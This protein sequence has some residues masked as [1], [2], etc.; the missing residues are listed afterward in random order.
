MP[1][2]TFNIT[3]IDLY[4]MFII[5][6]KTRK[7]IAA[8]YGCSDVLIKKKCQEYQIKK[9]KEASDRNKERR[10]KKTCAFCFFEFEVVRFRSKGKWETRYCSKKCSSLDRYLP[11]H[12]KRGRHAA[13][14]AWAR[15]KLKGA[16]HPEAKRALIARIYIECCK[17]SID[18]GI[19]YEV[20]H[21]VPIERGGKH[22][23]NNL[24]ILTL[25]EN[26]RKGRKI[27]V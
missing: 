4:R 25:L 22:H 3:K 14:S 26:R 21:I 1:V 13:R 24:Q 5:E 7:E 10:V 9:S 18:E 20:D 27:L 2:K 19:K 15:C 12:E 23:E 17:K 8:F 16:L 11:V 6:N